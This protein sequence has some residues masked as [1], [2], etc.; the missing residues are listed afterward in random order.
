MYG[1]ASDILSISR[2]DFAI[3]HTQS[4]EGGRISEGL[5]STNPVGVFQ[6][7]N[8][9]IFCT[10]TFYNQRPTECLVL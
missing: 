3:T 6:A 7:V 4:D 5:Q 10:K 1:I 9:S 2:P 8:F